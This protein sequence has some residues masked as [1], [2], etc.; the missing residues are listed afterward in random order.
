[1][2]KIIFFDMDV[3]LIDL[4]TGQMSENTKLCLGKLRQNGIKICVATGRLP[5]NLPRFPSVD[6]D[7]WLTLNGSYC[8]DASGTVFANPLPGESA[9]KIA[10]NAAELGLPVSFAVEADGNFSRPTQL[11]GTDTV[12]QAMVQCPQA[13]CAGILQGVEGAKIVSWWEKAVDIIPVDGGKGRG[14][15]EMLA[16]YRLHR[17]EAMA[18]GD[19]DNDMEMLEAVGTGIA[20]GN[21][22]DQLKAVADGVCGPVWQDGVYHY[23]LEHGLI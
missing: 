5:N 2:I 11:S 1:M 21:A 17:S 23:C 15:R 3:T 7:A 4:H 13:Q 6:F 8:F 20:M 12:Y 9:R 18:F 16:Y 19:G 10:K 22:T 14:I